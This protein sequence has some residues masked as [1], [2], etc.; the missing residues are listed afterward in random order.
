MI[1]LRLN[2]LFQLINLIIKIMFV[3]LLFMI[4]G[5]VIIV[6]KEVIFIMMPPLF[7]F[8]LKIKSL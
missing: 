4:G 2:I 1:K 5:H 8:G 3:Y 7:L 6:I